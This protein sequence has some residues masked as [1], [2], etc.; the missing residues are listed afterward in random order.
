MNLILLI[1][2]QGTGKTWVMKS[3]IERYKCLKRQKITRVYWHGSEEQNGKAVYVTGKYDGTTYEGSDRLSL[4]VMMDYDRFLQYAQGK[5][6]LLEGDR[7][8]NFTVLEHPTNKPYVIKIDNDGSKGRAMRGTNQSETALKRIATRIDNIN[9]D[10]C[11]K[12][13]AEALKV[14]D[15]LIQKYYEQGDKK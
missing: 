14:I 1:G 5:F 9:P 7:F 11:V 15:E 8:T 12:D 2:K 3:I 10:L 4:A 13:S 6:I